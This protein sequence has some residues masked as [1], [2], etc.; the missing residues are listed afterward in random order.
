MAILLISHDIAVISALCHRVYVV[1]AGRIAEQLS[2]DAL[3]DGHAHH[4]YTQALLAA[5]PKMRP[6]AS[7]T[8]LATLPSAPAAAAGTTGCPFAPRCPRAEPV[9]T[10][11]SPRLTALADGGQVACHVAVRE[12]AESAQVGD[13]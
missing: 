7:S 3:I 1:Y 10:A 5:V 13:V 9:C 11:L 12:A 6:G 4:P 2:A 8:R